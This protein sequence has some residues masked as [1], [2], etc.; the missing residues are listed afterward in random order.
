MAVEW[1][2]QAPLS[3]QE[4]LAEKA[5]ATERV[6][7]AE[8]ERVAVSVTERAAASVTERAAASVTAQPGIAEPP[9]LAA[10]AEPRR[11]NSV[12][13]LWNLRKQRVQLQPL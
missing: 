10:E 4:V 7:V 3:R 2:I 9:K 12:R 1:L 8:A 6:A 11:P 13:V 5:E